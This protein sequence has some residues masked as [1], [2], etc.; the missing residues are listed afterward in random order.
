MSTE[1]RESKYATVSGHELFQ[2]TTQRRE[3]FIQIPDAR[4][5]KFHRKLCKKWLD[6]LRNYQLCISNFVGNKSCVV[7]NTIFSRN[8]SKACFQIVLRRP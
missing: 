1:I 4:K 6:L 8:V 3:E 5:S 7:C 2:Q